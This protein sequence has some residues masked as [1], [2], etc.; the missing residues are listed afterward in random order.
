MDHQVQAVRQ[1]GKGSFAIRIRLCLG[2]RI[3]LLC[4]LGK[5]LRTLFAGHHIIRDLA[6]R[7]SLILLRKDI[8]CVVEVVVAILTSLRADPVDRNGFPGCCR[9]APILLHCH[10]EAA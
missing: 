1:I 7:C 8:C 4:G 5:T 6:S 10:R 2:I 3:Q 9:S